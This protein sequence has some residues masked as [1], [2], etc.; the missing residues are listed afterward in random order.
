MK[1]VRILTNVDMEGRL[2]LGWQPVGLAGLCP[3][4]RVQATLTATG[5]DTLHRAALLATP[6]DEEKMMG[7]EYPEAEEDFSL[8]HEFLRAAGIPIDSDLDVTSYPG[9]IVIR[10]SDPLNRL[11]GGLRE[12]F[13]AFGIHPETVREVMRRRGTSHEQQS[14]L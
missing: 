9:A 12:L 7:S 2:V 1:T 11:P 8:P 3:G 5:N 14:H 13:D 10:P 6:T 4:D